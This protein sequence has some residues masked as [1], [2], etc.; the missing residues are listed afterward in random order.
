[1]TPTEAQW[2]TLCRLVPVLAQTYWCIRYMEIMP[3]GQLAVVAQYDSERQRRLVFSI[4]PTG[5]F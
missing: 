2:T 5:D 4:S 1:M 3:G